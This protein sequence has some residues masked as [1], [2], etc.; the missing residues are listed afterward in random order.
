MDQ[1]QEALVQLE[2]DVFLAGVAGVDAE[3]DALHV[4][5]KVR[6]D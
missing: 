6:E 5:K 1:L 2:G 3:D 4:E